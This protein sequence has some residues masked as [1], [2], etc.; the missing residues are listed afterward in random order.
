MPLKKSNTVPH[1]VII[2]KDRKNAKSSSKEAKDATIIPLNAF[3]VSMVDSILPF[4]PLCN[5]FILLTTINICQKCLT[6]ELVVEK[7]LSITSDE[8]QQSI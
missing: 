1:E 3:P 5:F 4:L 8:S 2:I 7:L 6:H